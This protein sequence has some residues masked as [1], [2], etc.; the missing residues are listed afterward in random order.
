MMVAV[1]D[2]SA[3]SHSDRFK[4]RGRLLD[5]WIPF[6]LPGI[7][8]YSPE[9]VPE[10]VTSVVVCSPF[11][12]PRPDVEAGEFSA[13]LKKLTVAD[14][15]LCLKNG[16][17]RI[18]PRS[19]W[20]PGDL[21]CGDVVE[22]PFELKFCDAR[23]SPQ[24]VEERVVAL[25]L[26]W[27]HS[28]GVVVEDRRNFY[29]EGLIPVGSGSV[30]GPG[31]V[32]RGNSRVGR[33]VW[34]MSTC[35][36]ENADIGDDCQLLPGCVIRDSHVG[37]GARVG[38]FAHLRMQTQ[39]GS[40][41]RV[42]N[43]VEIKKSVIGEGSKASHLA[44]LGDARVGRDVNVGAGTITCNYDGSRKHATEIED[45][46]FVGSG[47]EL[48]APVRLGRNSYVGAGST[49]TEDVPEDSLA[50]ARQR[51]RNIPGWGLRKRKKTRG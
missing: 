33:N 7:P 36:L 11:S 50:I 24:Q 39:V 17:L 28:R 9:S 5:F 27:L 6:C 15:G 32:F 4:F 13:W 43:F 49:I 45:G 29:M 26:E 10:S 1:V 31:N 35:W 16:A 51:Q 44:Y 12:L 23:R 2:P 18:L 48:V 14:Q 38:P 42:G 41:T 3:G 8:F 34:V 19:T 22:P 30:I 47:T 20:R 46:V 40:S 37:Q 25:Q 21:S